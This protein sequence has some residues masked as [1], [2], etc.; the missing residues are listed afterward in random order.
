MSALLE[1]SPEELPN[2]CLSPSPAAGACEDGH[3]PLM[4]WSCDAWPSC[5]PLC[6][7][8]LLLTLPQSR[9]VSSSSGAGSSPLLRAL[10]HILC[11]HSDSP[12]VVPSS[13]CASPWRQL[14]AHIPH[15][16]HGAAFIHSHLSTS[17]P[18][19]MCK[20]PVQLWTISIQPLHPWFAPTTPA[21]MLIPGTPWL[22]HHP[23]S[24]LQ[25]SATLSSAASRR[26]EA[27]PS[28]A[29]QPD[30][31]CFNRGAA[32]SSAVPLRR[33]AVLRTVTTL[34]WPYTPFPGKPSAFDNVPR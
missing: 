12:P 27:A 29:R 26:A 16:P 34:W 17:V 31:C 6:L 7:P 25:P 10:H 21:L 30:S 9:G 19:H 4:P 3:Q 18:L 28:L 20:C 14:R 33:V 13:A 2:L 22:S 15:C 11:L 32:D 8:P 5:V 23:S 24:L 1:S